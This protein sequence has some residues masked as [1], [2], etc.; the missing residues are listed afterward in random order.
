MFIR[1]LHTASVQ[2][3]YI[4]GLDHFEGGLFINQSEVITLDSASDCN[5]A[6]AEALKYGWIKDGI[7]NSHM[8][9]L[10][11]EYESKRDIT[12]KFAI[13]V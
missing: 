8:D 11:R 5:E 4:S 9:D 6:I 10:W 3:R 1:M 13:N 12:G 2:N 7:N